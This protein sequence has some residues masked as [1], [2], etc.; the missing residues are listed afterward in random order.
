MKSKRNQFVLAPF[1][2]SGK[3][4]AAVISIAVLASKNH[5]ENN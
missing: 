2:R 1:W 5:Y 3:V 4:G